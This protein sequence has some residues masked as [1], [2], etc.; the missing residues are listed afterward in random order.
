MKQKVNV[1]LIEGLWVTE[2]IGVRNL[3]RSA[4]LFSVVLR[5]NCPANVT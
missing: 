3:E 4:F 1:K 5:P 2:K